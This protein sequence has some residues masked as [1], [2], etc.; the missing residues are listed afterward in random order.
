EPLL[1]TPVSTEELLLGKGIS[2]LIPA[3]AVSLVCYLITVISVHLIFGS[4]FSKILYSPVW[5]L[6][7]VL[8]SPLLGLAA[9]LLGVITSAR[10]TDIKAAQNYSLFLIFP[11]YGLIALQ[12]LG[13]IPFNI[14]TMSFYTAVLLFADFILLKTA[15]SVFSRSRI[16]TEWR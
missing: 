6:G 10:H 2:S 3:Y 13:I 11:L 4:S 12:F 9:F 5:L 15:V 7:V 16:L 1:A 14:L 8:I